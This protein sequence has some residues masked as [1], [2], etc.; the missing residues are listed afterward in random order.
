MNTFPTLSVAAKREGF[1]DEYSE[2]AVTIANPKSGYPFIISNFTFDARN[3]R[4]TL[5]RVS[6]TDKET[7]ET[8]YQANKT[9]SFNWLNEQDNYSYEMV[10]AH[11]PNCELDGANNEWK[12]GIG[13]IQASVSR[14]NAGAYGFGFYGEGAYG[15]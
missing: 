4:F 8:F 14:S 6:Q 15:K 9:I 11:K 2:D 5:R 12:I 10:F 7:F 13:L 3:I 1:A